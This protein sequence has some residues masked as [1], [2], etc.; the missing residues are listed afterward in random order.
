MSKAFLKYL[1][2]L[3]LFGTNGIV[4]ANIALSSQE[5]VWFRTLLGSVLLVGIFLIT[6][7]R[8]TSWQ[9]RR[10]FV[11]LVLSGVAMAGG[12][13]FV[14]EAYQ[15]VG[16]GLGTLLYYCGPVLVLA[17]SPLVFGER[18]TIR[19]LLGFAVVFVGLVLVNGLALQDGAD[20]WGILCGIGAA[21]TYAVMI[22]FNKKAGNADGFE[23]SMIQ[24]VVAFV[25]VTVFVGSTCGLDIRV[26]SEAWP[27]VLVLGLLNT[28]L[29][30]YWYFSSIGQL[31]AQTVSVVG[32]AEPL[33]A[34]IFSALLLG[35]SMLPL[36]IVGAV[37]IIGGAA[38]CELFGTPVRREQACALD[39]ESDRESSCAPEC[40]PSCAPGRAQDCAPDSESACE[41]GLE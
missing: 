19:K 15:R 10:Q 33:S 39:R 2:S 40:E 12:W 8:L 9:N 29:G 22:C 37:C 14:Y 35:E 24:L 28:G 4:A 31:R 23:N 36:Q 30:C 32:Y 7:R 5:I 11:F 17:A 21:L 16:V 1:A 6:R 41:L 26:P 38:F 13:L 20:V 25:V 3:L 34:V 18:L 27:Y